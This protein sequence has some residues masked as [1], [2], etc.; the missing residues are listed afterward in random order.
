MYIRVKCRVTER[1]RLVNLRQASYKMLKLTGV[2]RCMPRA[3]A[4]GVVGTLWLGVARTLYRE[5]SLDTS[6][7]TR[8]TADMRFNEAA[9]W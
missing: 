3:E 6:A 5:L 4:G 1:G 8:H 2:A 7:V 9:A